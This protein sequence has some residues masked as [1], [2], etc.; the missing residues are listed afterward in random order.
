MLT[1]S[2]QQDIIQENKLIRIDGMNIVCK[3]ERLEFIGNSMDRIALL[4]NLSKCLEPISLDEARAIISR[5]IKSNRNLLICCEDSRWIGLQDKK[6][7]SFELIETI[8]SLSNQPKIS[9]KISSNRVNCF[10]TYDVISSLLK[11][12]SFIKLS[13]KWSVNPTQAA[14][15]CK[16]EPGSNVFLHIKNVYGE[17]DSEHYQ[18]TSLLRLQIQTL[19][20]WQCV[21]KSNPGN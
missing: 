2:N 6:L 1:T 20:D 3:A 17:R 4:L 16:P 9:S 14:L 7:V 19:A 18:I 10:A 8:K 15:F 12:T 11:N 21:N 5:A 13:A